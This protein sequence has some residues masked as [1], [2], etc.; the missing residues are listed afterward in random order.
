MLRFLL[1]LAI[2]GLI[3][4]AIA[5]VAGARK[6]ET[7]G[8]P[9]WLWVVVILLVPVVGALAWIMVRRTGGPAPSSHGSST[10]GPRHTGPV[11][12]DDDPDFLWRLDQERRRRTNHDDQP[13]QQ[14]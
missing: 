5:D 2:I 12:P 10:S 13:P 7:G 1:T 4:Y 3:V 11:A 6:E 9:K 8:L 14:S